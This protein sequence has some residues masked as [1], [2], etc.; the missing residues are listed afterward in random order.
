MV[1]GI[2][3]LG[4]TDAAKEVLAE[5]GHVRR[6]HWLDAALLMKFERNVDAN[7]L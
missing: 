6:E 1:A 2:G 4:S 7:H 5:L 3:D